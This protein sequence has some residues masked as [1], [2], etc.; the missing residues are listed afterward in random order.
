[1]DARCAA[2]FS[3]SQGWKP[4]NASELRPSGLNAGAVTMNQALAK[5]FFAPALLRIGMVP[6]R[7]RWLVLAGADTSKGKP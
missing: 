7:L 6:R 5:L 2:G 1:V 4:S 3:V